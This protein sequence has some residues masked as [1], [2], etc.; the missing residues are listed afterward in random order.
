MPLNLSQGEDERELWN[1][2]PFEY[3]ADPQPMGGFPPP[4]IN[5]DDEKT[6]LLGDDQ[7]KGGRGGR[8]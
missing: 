6:E 4:P 7:P 5:P 3:I 1:K 2:P 8:K